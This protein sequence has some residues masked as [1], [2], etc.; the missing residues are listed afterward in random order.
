MGWGGVSGGVGGAMLASMANCRFDN[1]AICASLQYWLH[2]QPASADFHYS[3]T[4]HMPRVFVF[5]GIQ[6]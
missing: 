2:S 6:H 3:K 4:P 1:K 5:L